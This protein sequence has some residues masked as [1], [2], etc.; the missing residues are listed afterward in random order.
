MT[1]GEVQ[2]LRATITD[3]R[4]LL[5]LARNQLHYQYCIGN[6]GKTNGEIS[7]LIAV[8]NL[9]EQ[10]LSG[11]TTPKPRSRNEQPNTHNAMSDPATPPAEEPTETAPVPAPEQEPETQTIAPEEAPEEA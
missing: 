5:A 1:V 8:H 7:D 2:T 9:I 11:N 3:L 10:T 4:N 6:R